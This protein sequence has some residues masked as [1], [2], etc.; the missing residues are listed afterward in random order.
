M[1]A[2]RRLRPWPIIGNLPLPVHPFIRPTTRHAG[3]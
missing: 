1:A 3:R 2:Y